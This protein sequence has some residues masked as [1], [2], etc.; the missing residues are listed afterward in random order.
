MHSRRDVLKGAVIGTAG[1]IAA[2]AGR[3]IF[4]VTRAM[5]ADQANS[6]ATAAARAARSVLPTVSG[7][8]TGGKH[9]W[10]FGAYFG[11]IGKRGYVE[12]EFFLSGSATAF[13]AVGDLGSDGK[14]NVTP[15]TSAT[16][17]TRIV[18]RRPVDPNV[19]NGTVVV[20]WANVSNGYDISFA[21]PPGLYDGFA[22]VAVSAQQVGIYGFPS[23]KQGLV[24]WDPGRYGSLS[25]LSDAYCYDIFTQAARAIGPERSSSGVDPMGGLKVRKLIAI[26]GSQSGTR[27]VAYINGIQPRDKVFDALMPLVCAG[28]GADFDAAPAHPDPGGP[29]ASANGGHSRAHRTKLRDDLSVPVMAMNSETEALFYYGDRQPDTTRFVYWEVPGASHGGTGQIRLIRQKTERDGVGGP[30]DSKQHISDVCWLPTCDAAILH[31]HRWINGGRPPPSQPRID[32]NPGFLHLPMGSIV[33]AGLDM[34]YDTRGLLP[35]YERDAFG[36]AK[37][38]VRLPELE[39]PI[40]SYRGSGENKLLGQT[41]PFPPE[42]IAR[43]YRT[44]EV[45]VQKVTAAARAAER[46]GVILPYRVQEYIEEANAAHV[47]S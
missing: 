46:A 32:I 37:G 24:Q 39:V 41:F 40:A 11:D 10:P 20:E 45:Y 21:D 27:L 26:G 9:G 12:E 29:N 14:W 42:Q 28:T 1:V 3:A 25:I 44:H 16:Y 31:V 22:Y 35:Y 34:K 30:G 18:V 17:K 2:T 19:F 7:P 5:A 13:Q 33:L 36:N 4:G 47:P 38:G 6:S 23:K 15:T 8:I 43:L